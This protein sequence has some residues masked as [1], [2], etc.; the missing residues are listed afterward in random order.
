MNKYRTSLFVS[1]REASSRS[2]FPCLQVYIWANRHSF[3]LPLLT[4]TAQ[5]MLSLLRIPRPQRLN[6]LLKLVHII[7]DITRVA[8]RLCNSTSSSTSSSSSILP[9]HQ[10]L[11]KAKPPLRLLQWR[12]QSVFIAGGLVLINR[13]VFPSQRALASYA[14][15]AMLGARTTVL[16]ARA[17]ALGGRRRGIGVGPLLIEARA[18]GLAAPWWGRRR[19]VASCASARDIARGVAVRGYG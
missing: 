14:C 2:L 11:I 15:A 16:D 9:I 10:I 3:H 17:A 13:R 6:L 19:H 12:V 4:H 7:Q 8:S 18:V 5:N 1:S